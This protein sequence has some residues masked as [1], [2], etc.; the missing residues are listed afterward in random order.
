MKTLQINSQNQVKLFKFVQMNQSTTPV[1]Y[2]VERVR[3]DF[4]LKREAVIYF[5]C[6]K[7]FV[8]SQ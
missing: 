5:I 6:R 8:S 1:V 2:I 3:T 4:L 7:Q